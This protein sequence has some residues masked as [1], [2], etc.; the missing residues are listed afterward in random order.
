MK[1]IPLT[2][3]IQKIGNKYID[4]RK[5]PNGHILKIEA[6]KFTKIPKTANEKKSEFFFKRQKLPNKK[7]KIEI[8]IGSSKKPRSR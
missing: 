8:D 2:K 6:I 4:E 7:N 1:L 3:K 5:P